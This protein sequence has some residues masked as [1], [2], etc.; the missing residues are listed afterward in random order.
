MDQER[1]YRFVREGEIAFL[2]YPLN[3]IQ[4][5]LPFGK[6]ILRNLETEILERFGSLGAEEIT[7]P[8]AV[9]SEFLSHLRQGELF[10]A[11]S[12]EDS[13]HLSPSAEVQAAFVA[14]K[15][16]KSHRQIPLK[17]FSIGTAHRNGQ[18]R[19]LIKSKE[20]GFYE[21]N[22]F[23]E[24]KEEAEK[25]L[26]ESTTS[27][28]KM[29]KKLGIP[30]IQ[31]RESDEESAQHKFYTPFKFSGIFGGLACSSLIGT[32]YTQQFSRGAQS[33]TQCS[34]KPYQLNIGLT[35][36]ILTAYLAHHS[37]ERGFVLDKSISPQEIAI[38]DPDDSN[39]ALANPESTLLKAGFKVATFRSSNWRIGQER[40][41]I[42]GIPISIS[43]G[44]SQYL[45]KRRDTLEEE[46]TNA[47]NLEPTIKKILA[48]YSPRKSTLPV[49]ALVEN[50]NE[51]ERNRVYLSDKPFDGDLK[52]LGKTADNSLAYVVQKY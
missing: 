31:V 12:E 14:S 15:I 32:R 46:R 21:A 39:S 6:K 27:L 18:R 8:E 11:C 29:F 44:N 51:F 30:T 16:I 7:L 33:R 9:P 17:F 40:I 13:F 4:V 28:D 50:Q 43:L 5:L 48:E 52:L 49:S 45:I 26:A 34:F 22:F 25:G 2:D 20:F 1:F 10:T 3:G 35:T 23:Y 19:A 42:K 37:D 38:I 41:F 47:C 36:R 24:N